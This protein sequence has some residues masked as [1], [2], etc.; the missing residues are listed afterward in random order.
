MGRAILKFLLQIKICRCLNVFYRFLFG[1]I[2]NLENLGFQFTQK[3]RIFFPA[4]RCLFGSGLIPS[5][6]R[7]RAQTIIITDGLNG[8]IFLEKFQDAVHVVGKPFDDSK[9]ACLDG[10]HETS[11]T[12]NLSILR[13]QFD[14]EQPTTTQNSIST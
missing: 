13:V 7:F 6:Q 3:I 12:M 4:S 9:Y 14:I 10:R 2:Q 8:M 11:I 5:F 1:F